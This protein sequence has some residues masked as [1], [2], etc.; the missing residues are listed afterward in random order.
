MGS[1]TI[2]SVSDENMIEPMH[3]I[4]QVKIVVQKE[5]RASILTWDRMLYL[6]NT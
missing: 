4:I 2:L 6:T 1:I 5:S 3:M